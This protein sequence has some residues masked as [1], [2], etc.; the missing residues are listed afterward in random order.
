MYP[1]K[2]IINKQDT[3]NILPMFGYKRTIKTAE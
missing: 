1:W 3:P 2:F